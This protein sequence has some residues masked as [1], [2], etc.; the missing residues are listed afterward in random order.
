MKQLNRMRLMCGLPI[1]PSIEITEKEEVVT[2]ARTVPVRKSELSAKDEKAL[3]K[4]VAGMKS[5]IKHIE[6]AIKALEKVPALDFNAKVPRFIQELEDLLED[7]EDGMKGHLADCEDGARK[8][9]RAANAK[10]REEEEEALQAT[11]I[12]EDVSP[13]DEELFA[14]LEDSKVDES[15]HFY[16][17]VDS[18][19][20]YEDDET[21][22]INVSD[23]SSNDEQVQDRKEAKNLKDENPEQLRTGDERSPQDQSDGLDIEAEMKIPAAIKNQLADAAK[24]ARAEAKKMQV[25]NK[26]ASYFYDDLARAFE[27]LKGHLDKGT[28]YDF[29]LAQNFAQS[30][31]GPMIHKMPTDV[32]KFLTNGGETRSLK[33]Y[34]KPVDKKFPIE[35]PRNTIK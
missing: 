5:A 35:G 10:R 19:K 33:D 18:Y 31:M 27:D 28:R 6:Q 16:A 29:K 24:E 34:M 13:S 17:N 7:G 9:K 15:M 4:G 25:S 2:E 12:D 30:L 26:D 1:D 23:G 3:G 22:P 32:W 20:D 14:E 11:S 8:F 21:K